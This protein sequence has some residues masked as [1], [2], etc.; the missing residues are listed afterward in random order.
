MQPVDTNEE[1][2]LLRGE[3]WFTLEEFEKKLENDITSY[4][5]EREQI[6]NFYKKKV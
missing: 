1:I 4:K 2:E 5:I 3:L 6:I